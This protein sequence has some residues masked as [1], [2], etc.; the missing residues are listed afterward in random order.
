VLYIAQILLVALPEFEPPTATP[1]ASPAIG[2]LHRDLVEG[3]EELVTAGIP[4]ERSCNFAIT[5][6][7][8]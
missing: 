3:Q 6:L 7:S 1:A 5:S 4:R 2:A 8:P